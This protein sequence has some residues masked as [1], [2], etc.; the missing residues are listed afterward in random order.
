MPVRLSSMSSKAPPRASRA[1]RRWTARAVVSALMVSALPGAPRPA[2]AA[3]AAA[4]PGG[5]PH[6]Q[7][8][9]RPRPVTGLKSIAALTG[10]AAHSAAR[11]AAVVS[12]KPARPVWPTPSQVDV[13]LSAAASSS[14]PPSAMA[15]RLA[16]D[17]A[18]K[19]QLHV[20]TVAGA[21]VSGPS[22]VRVTVLDHAA[23]VAAGA[24]GVIA[25]VARADGSA[26]AGRVQIT[27]DY[28]SWAQAFGGNFADR[29][30]LVALPDCA[31]TTPASSKCRAQTPLKYVNDRAH[32]RLTATVTLPGGSK[33]RPAPNTTAASAA[34]P[35]M[36]LAAT[37]SASG[38]N[39]T[40]AASSL[41]ASD[42]WST[43]GNSGSFDWS[44]PLSA[45]PS[46]GSG[47][48]SLSLGYDSG[49][50]D[51]RTTVS[52]GQPSDL[53]EGFD[54]GGA[55]SYIETTY[56]PC[57]KV[58]PTNW[59]S[60]GDMC[61][62]VANATISGGAHAG[63]LV[64]DDADTTKWRLAVDD[65]TRV[66]LLTG[67]TGGSNNTANQA[68]WKLTGTDGT[69]FLYGANRLPAAYGGTGVDNP[70]YSTWSEPVFGTGSG[71]S[72]NDPT[73][74]EDPQTCLQAWRWNLDYVIDTHGNVTRMSYA[75]ELDNYQHKTATTA[76]TRSGFLREIDYGWRQ[77]DVAASTGLLA[78][79]NAAAAWP[80]STI[81]FGY[82]PRCLP[83]TTGCPTSAVTVTSGVATTG[84]ASGN[85]TAFTDVPYDQ[86]CDAGSTSCAVY[87]PAYF[88]TVRLTTVQTAVNTGAAMPNQPSWTPANYEAVDAYTFN[89]SFPAP[90][91]YSTTGNR[92]QLRLDSISHTGYL[93][94]SDGTV[95]STP[96]PAVNLG[97]TGT[98]PNRSQASSLY[99]TAQF[100]RFRLDDITDELGAET[101]V[102]YGQ[103]NNL[104]CGTTA[105]P[106]TIANAT[107]C[108]PEYFNNNGTMVIDWFNK[109]LVTGVTVN[110]D[111]VK[112]TG[113]L[114]SAPHT[115][116]YTYIG[117]PAWHTNDSEQA[118]PKYRTVDGFRGF[119]QVQ[120][121]TSGEASGHNAKS[122]TTYFQGMDQDPSTYVCLND[123]H[124]QAPVTTACPSGGY[125]D[126][127]ALAGQALEEQ[128]YASETSTSVI[129]D[130]IS[131]PQD[132]TDAGMV[133]AA[134]TR[135]SG[136]PAQRAHFSHVQ[137]KITYA[138]LASG[139][140]RRSEIDYTYD[141]SLPSFT[142]G[143]GVGGN[144]HLLL[145]D[146]KGDTDAA[147]NPLGNVQELCTF[148]GYAGNTA[149]GADGAQWTA[150][151]MTTIVSTV[152][153][154]QACTTTSETAATTVSQ[155]QMLYDNQPPGT[156]AKG[157]VTT[158]ESTPSFNGSWVMTAQHGYDQYGR[159]I[160]ATDAD[161]HTTQTT[162][163]PATGVLPK[164]VAAKNPAGWT[165]T[166]TLDRGRGVTESFLDVNG[167]QSDAVYDGLGRVTQAWKADHTKVLNPNSPD[168]AFTY[169]VFGATA[170]S[171][172]AAPNPYVES[173]A[174]REDG[175]YGVSVTILDGFGD[176]VETQATPA[177]G[178]NGLVS[179][180]TE[181]NSLGKPWRAASAHW[182]SANAPSGRF[183]NYG[184]ALPAQTVT[185]YDG[186]SRVLTVAQYHN[187]A[188][189]PGAVATTAYPG[190]DRTDQTAA[191]GNGIAAAG[192]T[193]TVT[194]VRG[195]TTAM[196]TYHNSPPSPTGNVA[197]AD[198]TTYGFSHVQNGTTLTTT[199]GTTKN[200]WKTTTTDLLGLHVTKSDPDSGTSYTV[201]DNAG[202][203][204]QTQDARGQYLSYYY[205]AL[206]RRSAEYGAAWVAGGTPAASTLLATWAY[207]TAP[208][209]DGKPTRG[210]PVSS[211]RYTDSGVNQYISAVTGYDAAG[212]SLGNKVT[213][214][215]A[216]GNGSLAG[217]YQTN[218]VYTPVTGL[219]D[220]TDLPAA[221]GLPA[222]TVYNSYNVNGL[223]LATG[224]NA[225]YVVDTQYD[226]LGRILSRTL[227][228]YPYQTVQQNL[229]D[230]ATGR[231]TN[232]FIDAT[233]G[234][235]AANPSQL[236]TYSI[237]DNSY[238]YDAAGR[239]TSAAD[240]QN[241]TVSGSY[242]PGAAARDLQCYTY[243]YAGRVTAA[244]ADKG[245]QTPSA[246]TNLSSPTTAMGGL[247]SCADS[248]SNNP[249]TSASALGGP[250]PYWQT[251]AFD[252]TGAAGLGNGALTGNRSSI[253]DHDTTGNTA[254]DVTR[255][256]AY[257]AA[258]TTNT[259]AAATTGGT[260]PHLLGSVTATGGASGTDTYT[261]DGEGNTTGRVVTTQGA[262]TGNVN[263]ALT[264]DAEGHL[265]T[266][267]N[268]ATNVTA[269][270][271]YDASGNT[272]MRRDYTTGS[273]NGTVTL[274]LGSTELHMATSNGAVSGQRYYSYPSA[275]N[276]VADSTGS[277]TYEIANPQS[278][279]DTTVNA[280]TGKV[281]ARRYSKPFGDT[282][283]TPAS[284]W[285]DDHT[286]L[287]KSTD[288]STGLTTVGAR[289]YDAQT[290]RF[291]SADPV[292]QPQRP[293]DVGGYA[294]AGN[295]P[296]N[297]SDPTGLTHC[298]A[299][300]GVC[301]KATQASVTGDG[302]TSNSTD[303]ST[304]Q[305]P[306]G[307]HDNGH[308][309]GENW[310]PQCQPGFHYNGHGCGEDWTSDPSSAGNYGCVMNG[311]DLLCS[312]FQAPP[313]KTVTMS[314]AKIVVLLAG[315][316]LA[317]KLGVQA[318]CVAR[319][320]I[321]KMRSKGPVIVPSAPPGVDT[322]LST[323]PVY[324]GN[325]QN[326]DTGPAEPK[327]GLS[328][329]T[330][331][332]GDVLPY[333]ESQL[334]YSVFDSKEN[335]AAQ[336]S[337]IWIW[338]LPAGTVLPDD[339]G[340]LRD[341]GEVVD[342]KVMP[343]GH[344]SIVPIQSM[345][346][347]HYK[348]EIMNL[349]WNLTD[350]KVTGSN[351]LACRATGGPYPC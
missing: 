183:H 138:P 163:I 5:R 291:I 205:D 58:D 279:A 137:R 338:E 30:A 253:T 42:S 126:D 334:G 290:G 150:Y 45:P 344:V 55:S 95:A 202:L 84:I 70:T 139:A 280:A 164:Q 170:G 107:L 317:C 166:S 242:N 336:R 276:I 29:L 225:D 306:P 236:N 83:S 221:G 66:Q 241:W 345:S 155:V 156:V 54:L 299:D 201:S 271:V 318:A 335:L 312:S 64:R 293:Q 277:L 162:Y 154:G 89:Q 27:I 21:A 16:A 321:I 230:A 342:G 337:S 226:Q 134:H 14:A 51:G 46:L 148:T 35:A 196:W 327:E 304:R 193:S 186:D 314:D 108:Y 209:S 283:G 213:I 98:L 339:L 227:G 246:T 237:D 8:I 176:T 265:A 72:C 44:Y 322:G 232:T 122:L 255:T 261:Y 324:A 119:R 319:D 229:Y 248:T 165:S 106:A 15:Q 4:H 91:D 167:R 169:G 273:Q 235:N 63:E 204:T 133:T 233:A 141:N 329:E 61:L 222:E 62:G 217:S 10:A 24:D 274:Y 218:N 285:P 26:A 320:N 282:R 99:N 174:L 298:D 300:P 114:Y 43:S 207:D 347:D 132:P 22:K 262:G 315:L 333:P 239:V 86:H 1:W 9:W 302:G 192:A 37:A 127:N 101:V 259:A 287:G 31:L 267:A 73:G 349:G 152:P 340:L 238:T 7:Q 65:G 11:S 149:L 80:A 326:I 249:P 188:A 90:Q 189:I 268:T 177:D 343:P 311:G 171:P 316:T 118:D 96:D 346:A 256:S 28:G 121:T 182:D 135:A 153:A 228:D 173:Q 224:G 332:Y 75:R 53:G 194:D 79:G 195:R 12:E 78:D 136:L 115:T 240:L 264:W 52:N 87:S 197:D 67:T 208:D 39:G 94:N 56:K 34:G 147:G 120:T 203:V 270:F 97:Y 181:Y 41:K 281:I 286:F 13:E 172:N 116:N 151:P 288:A 68:Y 307:F 85:A 69:Q 159:E 111:T 244:W 76:Y 289:T 214:P 32:H 81:R 105:P 292:F 77:T 184:D 145:T 82:A 331:I 284:S 254:N 71:T 200:T 179:T 243:D 180:Q 220:H 258:G 104:G 219:L 252:A 18:A 25:T 206:N 231:V 328:Y 330:N 309:C 40:Y 48:P 278:T 175:S 305:C 33:S 36:V 125:R 341:A 92:P 348:S 313:A 325:K 199:D 266:D 161:S 49:A 60:S 50:V 113:Y 251:Y 128:T 350:A 297:G 100:Y 295:D 310:D 211:T 223:L 250:A 74:S 140:L 17:S 59:A 88:S 123:S 117:S 158:N 263:E 19:M 109:Y 131:V 178:S 323:Y 160:S 234:Q 210:L 2:S 198:V 351:K 212:R 275:P 247:G 308:G 190:V 93:T 296:V 260:G 47:A 272:L 303:S 110:D 191:A 103:P 257:P 3:Q 6:Q 143:G 245:D 157:D 187:G 124:S 168:A 20:G 269:S 294:Y 130:V 23:A 102:T 185:T 216:D 301:S 57:A 112:G 142:G 144:G 38:A 146:D 129:S 215:M